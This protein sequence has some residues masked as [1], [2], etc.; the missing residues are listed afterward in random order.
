MG[1]VRKT[2]YFG[3]DGFRGE[4]GNEL[5][6]K[7]A[8]VIGKFLG[9]RLNE[10]L[11]RTKGATSNNHGTKRCTLK[12]KD[13]TEYFAEDDAGCD[14]I[15]GQGC[16]ANIIIGRDTRESSGLLFAAVAA[17]IRSTGADAFDAGIITTPGLSYITGS[18]KF[19]GGVMI[20]ASHNPYYD[21]G[22]KLFDS[23]GRKVDDEMIYDLEDYMDKA[24]QKGVFTEEY[25]L[26]RQEFC[27]GQEL[28]IEE[29][30]K[31]KIGELSGVRIGLD[32]ASGAAYWIA[33]EVFRRLGAEVYQVD[34]NPDGRN[35]NEGVGST[36]PE[37]L[38]RLVIK[39]GLDIGFAFDGDGDRCITVDKCGSIIDGDGEMF[40]L[41]TEMLR[42]GKLKNNKIVATIMSNSG[43]IRSLA[44]IGIE[45]E[46]CPVGDRFV[47]EKMQERD[48]ALGGEQS[49]H[50]IIGDKETGDGIFTAV[51]LASALKRSGNNMS[52]LMGGLSIF[53]QLSESI[54]VK[55]KG[56]IME[57]EGLKKLYENVAAEIGD[58]GRVFI[59]PSGTESLIRV[60][61]EHKNIDK[62]KLY[63][64]KL[65]NFIE[66]VADCYDR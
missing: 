32:T 8:Y 49:G 6:L 30:T 40:I 47:Y 7:H 52:M 44:A 29:L 50:I 65:K 27:G 57:S 55:D 35:I 17:G 56:A 61:V 66:S 23:Q 12:V 43:F 54:G 16:A 14:G 4:F 48:C 64:S 45:C 11:G 20:T 24:I 5:T 9:R 53:P 3:T 63:L 19:D 26:K 39:K 36:H 28:Y 33:P 21:N 46:S 18:Q 13:N 42:N 15:E 2:K 31:G 34:K 62:C 22:I 10:E 51:S 58:N 60:M 41:A 38:A 25:D 1:E 59:R 37:A